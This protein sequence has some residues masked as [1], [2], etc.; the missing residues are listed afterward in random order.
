LHSI[1]LDLHRSE[2][3][4]VLIVEEKKRKIVEELKPKDHG[5][6]HQLFFMFA[7]M[8]LNYDCNQEIGSL[9]IRKI[10]SKQAYY[11]EVTFSVHSDRSG[12]N[13]DQRVCRTHSIIE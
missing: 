12:L 13:S 4:A 10:C 11:L 5:L 6:T 7:P 2:I 3:E 8:W 1:F 9:F